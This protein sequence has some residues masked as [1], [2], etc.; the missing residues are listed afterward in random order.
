MIITLYKIDNIVKSQRESIQFIVVGATT[1][2]YYI[3]MGEL[4]D[5][6]FADSIISLVLDPGFTTL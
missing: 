5:L 6:F 4:A 2:Y 1:D 3:I